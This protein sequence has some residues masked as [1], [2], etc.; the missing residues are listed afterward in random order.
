ML[1]SHASLLLPSLAF[2]CRLRPTIRP[3]FS[4]AGL[5]SPAAA[6]AVVV[7]ASHRAVWPRGIWNLPLSEL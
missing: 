5:S 3:R 1:V 4:Y 7:V 6:A 2:T